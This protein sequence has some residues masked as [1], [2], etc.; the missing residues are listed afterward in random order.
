MHRMSVPNI[1]TRETLTVSGS[2]TEP[3]RRPGPDA[4]ESASS[5]GPTSTTRLMSYLP[6]P[7]PQ[8][9]VK[10][11][12]NQINPHCDSSLHC[13]SNRSSNSKVLLGWT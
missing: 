9:H 1:S 3:T 10:T 4:T 6:Q 2:P 8:I 13:D 11:Y 5:G 12:L 7:N